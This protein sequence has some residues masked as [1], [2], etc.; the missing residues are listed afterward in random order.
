MNKYVILFSLLAWGVFLVLVATL[1]GP[2]GASAAGVATFATCL[3][4]ILYGMAIL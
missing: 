2:A 1:G 4:V 3:L